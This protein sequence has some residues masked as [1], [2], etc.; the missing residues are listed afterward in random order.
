MYLLI[1]FSYIYC[2]PTVFK[3]LKLSLHL[4]L[5]KARQ[6]STFLSLKSRIRDRNRRTNDTIN[7][8]LNANK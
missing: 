3:A 5:F 8:F 1:Y 4:Q 7:D 2:P 6:G